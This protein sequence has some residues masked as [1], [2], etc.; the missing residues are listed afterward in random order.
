MSFCKSITT[1]YRDNLI[2][3]IESKEFSIL[4][5]SYKKCKKEKKYRELLNYIKQNLTCNNIDNIDLYDCICNIVSHEYE[6]LIIK[7][8]DSGTFYCLYKKYYKTHN[9]YELINYIYIKIECLNID[10]SECYPKPGKM[11]TVFLLELSAGIIENDISVKETVNYYWNTY[12]QEFTKCLVV[13][14][15]GSL[16]TTLNLLEEYYNYGFRYFVGFS[17]STIVN[18]VLD[19]F[20][21]HPD[22]SGISSTSTAASLY[23]PK[24]IFR[25]TP[26][27]NNIIDSISSNLENKMVNYIYEANELASIDLI[28]YIE[29]IPGIILVKYPISDTNDLN[30]LASLNT[31]HT[32]EIMLIYLFINK[33]Y[34]LDLFKN[35]NPVLIY[36][37]TQYDIS[38]IGT[39]EITDSPSLNNNYNTSLFKGIQTS[40]LW[41]NGYYSLGSTNFS[42]VS[43]NILNLLNQFVDNKIVDNINSHFCALLFNPVSKDIND[44]SFLIEKY[45]GTQFVN[46]NLYI[47]DPYLGSYTAIFIDSPII[48][49]DIIPILP[50]KPFFGK[51]IALLE[52]TNNITQ[53]DLIFRDSIY[54]YWYKD[55]SLSKFPIVDT[56]SLDVIDTI[57]DTYYNLGYRIF[58]GFTRSTVLSNSLSWFRNHPEARG[59]SI[60]SAAKFD[61]VPQNIFRLNY[62]DS[63][64]IQLLGISLLNDATKIYYIYKEGNVQGIAAYNAFNFLYPNKL[65]TLIIEEKE[66]NLNATTLTNFFNGNI[67]TDVVMLYLQGIE[68][69]INVYND[70]AMQATKAKQYNTAVQQDPNISEPA[71]SKLNLIYFNMIS[72]YPN[73]SFLW[74]E[75][76]QYLTEKYKRD[77]NSFTLLLSMTMINYIL[78]GK[79][80]N[81]LGSHSGVL[82][83]NTI[84]RNMQYAS[85]LFKQ[86]QSKI[87]GFIN[88]SIILNDPFLGIFDANFM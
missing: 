36:T 45:N 43:L 59:I 38:G 86:Y 63:S 13:D 21:L 83:F 72:T 34:Y 87:N 41:R 50:N 79:D 82:Q 55:E 16:I 11:K 12:P 75:N 65:K 6:K 26:N 19:W 1:E 3:N 15:K 10:C 2:R 8:L 54:Y 47:Y 85:L 61:N 70:P 20:N 29:E 4:Y 40:I 33:Q 53:N 67:D 88:N 46:T 24:N 48:Q 73:T 31:G 14:T 77:T 22:A 23:I 64:I 25:M 71:S 68:T 49:K 18:G 74:N 28:K 57:L 44:F 27:D 51:A 66:T 69:Y 84:T 60:I 5:F 80:I 56:K 39:P 32:G 37:N 58:L 9:N 17:R 35:P 42:I 81:L 62:S 7:L 78:L 76:R 52:L 30:N